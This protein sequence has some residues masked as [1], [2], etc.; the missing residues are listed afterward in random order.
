MT[1]LSVDF[2]AAEASSEIRLRF[3]SDA[4]IAHSSE[5]TILKVR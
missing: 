2:S 4:Q 5:L 3:A 1:S